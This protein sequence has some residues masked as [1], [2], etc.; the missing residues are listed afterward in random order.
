MLI[1]TNLEHQNQGLIEIKRVGSN[2]IIKPMT[3]I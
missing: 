1:I 3:K 2:F